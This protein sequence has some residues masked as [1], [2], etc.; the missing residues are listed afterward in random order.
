M[1]LWKESN[2]LGI[3]PRSN[4]SDLVCI[5]NKLSDC[6]LNGKNLSKALNFLYTY[7]NLEYLSVKWWNTHTFHA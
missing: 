3:S 1:L 6:A 5:P 2:L 4:W 7:P